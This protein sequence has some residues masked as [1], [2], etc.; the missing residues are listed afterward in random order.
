[1][2]TTSIKKE[3]ILAAPVAD[4]VPHSDPMVLLD[5]LV[6]FTDNSLTAEVDIQ[7]TSRFFIPAVKGIESWVSIEY[8]AQAIAALAGVK[9]HLAGEP[10][11][12]GFLLG[13]RKMDIASPLMLAGQS[14][15]IHIEE[16]YMDDSG[17][18]AFSCSVTQDDTI[19]SEAKLNVFESDDTNQL[20]HNE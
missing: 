5:R 17:L 20:T 18:G 11:K 9:A 13:T 19:I 15:Q 10:V 14:Y 4:F 8:M 6:D 12:L 2:H 1:M 7:P 16:L 3:T